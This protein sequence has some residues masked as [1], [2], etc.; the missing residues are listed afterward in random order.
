SP[1]E[2]L[3]VAGNVKASAFIGDGSQL[4]GVPADGGKVT[5]T[6]DTISGPL[7]LTSDDSGGKNRG[8]GLEVFQGGNADASVL[9]FRAGYGGGSDPSLV[10]NGARRVGIGTSSP[11]EKLEVAGNVKASAFIGD[12]SQLT[13]LPSSGAGGSTFST[14]TVTG[15]VLGL[16]NG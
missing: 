5:K 8:A 4:T 9:V 12:G 16:A 13:G 3:E 11:A 15:G 7:R 6:G 10:V 1:S 2:K 14:V